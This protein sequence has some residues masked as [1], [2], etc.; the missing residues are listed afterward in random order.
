[1]RKKNKKQR[2]MGF[3]TR[4][5][6]KTEPMFILPD[7]AENIYAKLRMEVAGLRIISGAFYRMKISATVRK[8]TTPLH[9]LE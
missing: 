8:S 5:P 2:F 6:R 9:I 4:R 3:E 7:A 1:M